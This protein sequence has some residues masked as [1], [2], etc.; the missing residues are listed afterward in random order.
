MEEDVANRLDACREI[1][2]DYKILQ[3]R[4]IQLDALQERR[5]EL[6][7]QLEALSELAERLYV[8]T[9]PDGS[10]MLRVQLKVIRER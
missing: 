3:E 4:R 1:V 6:D 10:E 7:R 2:G 5:N 8:H 9:G